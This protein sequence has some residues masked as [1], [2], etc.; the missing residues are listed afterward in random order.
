MNILNPRVPDADWDLS[1]LFTFDHEFSDIIRLGK[2]FYDCDIPIKSIHGCYPVMWNAGR[3]VDVKAE[4]WGDFKTSGPEQVI[5]FWDN[6]WTP[7][8]CYLTFSNH[9][10]KK[11]HLEDPS[12]NFLLDILTKHNRRNVNGV[13]VS[14]DILSEYIRKKYRL[15]PTALLPLLPQ[16]GRTE[17]IAVL[18][19]FCTIGGIGM[20]P[21]FNIPMRYAAVRL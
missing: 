19:R 18:Q 1:G 2:T 13:I 20:Y 5:E 7:I 4:F 8:G 11:G 6:C 17:R 21:A 10:L 12:S 14:S 9:L 16:V 15:R 3:I